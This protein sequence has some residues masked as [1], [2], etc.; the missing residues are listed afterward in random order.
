[1]KK[2]HPI[3]SMDVYVGF[4]DDRPHVMNNGYPGKTS[5]GRVITAYVSKL[6][7]GRAYRD[8]RKAR[9]VFDANWKPAK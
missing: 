7:A 5:S 3:R 1:M 8:V 9:L 4:L 2:H 6:V